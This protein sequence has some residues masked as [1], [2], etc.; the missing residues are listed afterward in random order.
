MLYFHL[1]EETTAGRF[2]SI[3]ARISIEL[4]LNRQQNILRSFPSP[5]GREWATFC[6]WCAYMLDRRG[7]IGLG[8]PYILQDDDIDTMAPVPR[9]DL[10]IVDHSEIEGTTTARAREASRQYIIAM[11]KF[12]GLSGKACTL[13]NQLSD[14][15]KPI[16][17]Q[18]LE[19]LDYQVLQWHKSL[20]DGLQLQRSH[21]WQLA[22]SSTP[23]D[24]SVLFL[25][26]VLNARM[27]QLRNLIFRPILYHPSRI[28]QY[29]GQAQTAVEVAKES[30]LLLWT[31]NDST[32]IVRS[33]PVFFKHFLVSAFGL[34]LLGVVNAWHELGQQVALEFHLALD[35]FKMMSAESPLVMRYSTT[36]K[37]LEELAHR[38]G[39]PRTRASEPH[40]AYGSHGSAHSNTFSG[41]GQDDDHNLASSCTFEQSNLPGNG[42]IDTVEIRDEFASFLDLDAVQANSFFDFPLGDMISSESFQ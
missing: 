15:T 35:L 12:T 19:Y 1:D 3:T 13:M 11:T 37:G 34:L 17:C 5:E 23:D 36:I 42:S 40:A 16:S 39:L 22:R 4:G 25:Q 32:G 24:A 26:V 38:I 14:R 21:L 6:F 7:S 28:S 33:H 2:A 9:F 18:G 10:T 41:F 27:N 8:V 31:V 20:P 29:P 30:V